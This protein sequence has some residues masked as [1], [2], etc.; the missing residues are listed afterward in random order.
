MP[1]TSCAIQRAARG[2]PSWSSSTIGPHAWIL[3]VGLADDACAAVRT[4]HLVGDVELFDAENGEPATREVIAGCTAH[5]AAADDDRVVSV[6]HARIE[7][8]ETR[9]S[10]FGRAGPLWRK[11]VGKR[12]LC[13][14]KKPRAII[15]DLDGTLADTLR[16]I[17]EGYQA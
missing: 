10:K 1:S 5:G 3:E 11:C 15:F 17:A 2:V 8:A 12:N 14:M 6:G 9:R 7:N 16:D 4:A 13:G